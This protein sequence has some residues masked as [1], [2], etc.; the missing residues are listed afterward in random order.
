MLIA[1]FNVVAEVILYKK[2]SGGRMGDSYGKF[3][4][5]SLYTAF[6]HFHS[7]EW[8]FFSPDYTRNAAGFVRYDGFS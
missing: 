4:D 6:K 5:P 7:G 3:V 8:M 2:R 1:E